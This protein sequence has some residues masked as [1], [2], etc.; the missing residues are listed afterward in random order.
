M[1]RLSGAKP[2]RAHGAPP[3]VR[4]WPSFRGSY[5]WVHRGTAWLYVDAPGVVHGR[6]DRMDGGPGAPWYWWQT[7]DATGDELDLMRARWRVEQ[8]IDGS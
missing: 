8:G 3:E 6:V 1:V 2:A 4:F 5:G 7:A